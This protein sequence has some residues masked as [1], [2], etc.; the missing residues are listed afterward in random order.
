MAA[1]P[2]AHAIASITIVAAAVK[3]G[4]SG[5]TSTMRTSETNFFFPAVE[6]ADVFYSS[7]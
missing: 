4:K 3:L 7:I 1:I 2:I 6:R 5:T